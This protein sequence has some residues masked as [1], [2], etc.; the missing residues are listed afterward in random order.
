[1]TR[2]RKSNKNWVKF[3][4]VF[5]I[6]LFNFSKE[7]VEKNLLNRNQLEYKPKIV[8]HFEREIYKKKFFY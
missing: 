6:E 8:F 1:M 7:D 4:I 2:L 5:I 3:D